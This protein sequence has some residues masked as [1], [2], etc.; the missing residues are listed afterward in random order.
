MPLR[1]GQIYW[2]DD[3]PALSGHDPKRRPVIVVSPDSILKANAPR[4]L[5]VA[6]STSATESTAPDRI[7]LPNAQQN[8]GC[9]TGLP[10]PCWAVPAWLLPIEASRLYVQSGYLSAATRH[11]LLAAVAARFPTK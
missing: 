6:I 4:V 10:K 5:V 7:A 8:P 1:T 11:K 3:C 9:S 2:L